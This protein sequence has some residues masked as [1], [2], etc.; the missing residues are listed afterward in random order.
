[1]AQAAGFDLIWFGV[2]TVIA[3]EIGLLTPPFGLSVFTIKSA[4]D[5]PTLKR[6]RDLPRRRALR[7][8]DA[9][10]LR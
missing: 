3:V 8:G 10:V 7:R 1:V 6:R 9:G 5:D 2:L 4:M